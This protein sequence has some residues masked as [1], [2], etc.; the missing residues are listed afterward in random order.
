MSQDGKD[1]INDMQ[2]EPDH[3]PDPK[4]IE[5]ERNLLVWRKIIPNATTLL[6]NFVGLSAVYLGTLPDFPHRWEIA[7][8][9]IITS[10][11]LD[12]LDGPIARALKGTSRFGAELDSLADYVNFGVTPCIVLYLWSLN[13]LG[14]IGWCIT[15][16]YCLC[17]ACRLA[18]FN[19]GIDFNASAATRNFFTG[20]P[21]PAGAFMVLMPMYSKFLFGSTIFDSTWFVGGIVIFTGSLLVSS[22]P[23]FSSKMLNRS[24]LPTILIHYII[25]GIGFI[26]I[27]ASFL[28]SLW[29]SLLIAYVIYVCSF[30]FS[31]LQFQQA[32]KKK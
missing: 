3:H 7:A 31:Y 6:A 15:L 18:R 11:L 28:Y 4:L 19:S 24:M 20:V 10:G 22:I 25:A 8:L 1:T 12:G 9:C 5:Q 2:A 13:K 27:I 16:F 29:G 23:T 30:P 32:L 21:A 17:M 14:L 26:I